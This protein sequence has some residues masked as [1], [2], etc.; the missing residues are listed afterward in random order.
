[1]DLQGLELPPLMILNGDPFPIGLALLLGIAN[2]I[3]ADC[4]S[5]PAKANVLLGRI[6][7]GPLGDLH[8]V[9][10]RTVA[11]GVLWHVAFTVLAFIFPLAIDKECH[12]VGRC[13]VKEG[14]PFYKMI[15]LT[16]IS[17]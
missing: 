6:D 2:G 7:R 3:L 16:Y 5:R 12:A 1:M 17:R 9:G 4:K 14:M 13:H 10:R 8:L 15:P 11:R